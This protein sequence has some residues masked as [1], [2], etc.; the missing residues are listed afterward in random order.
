[1]QIDFSLCGD[2]GKYL[3]SKM[4]ADDAL[5][6]EAESPFTLLT[7]GNQ[8]IALYNPIPDTVPPNAKDVKHMVV[9]GGYA[10]WFID[11][12]A[13]RTLERM[14]PTATGTVRVVVAE[15]RDGE[16]TIDVSRN[17]MQAAMT[18]SRPLGGLAVTV[19]DVRAELASAGVVFGI[20]DEVIDAAVTSGRADSLVVAEGA[21]PR[22]GE[23]CRFETLYSEDNSN[24]PKVDSNGRAD[25]HELEHFVVV[26][27]GDPLMKRI[28]ATKGTPGSDVLGKPIQCKPGRDQSFAAKL[29][30]AEIASYNQNLLIAAI[31][32]LPQKVDRGVTVKPL[33]QVPTVDITTGNIHFEGSVKVTGDVVS[34]TT[35]SATEDIIVSG[36][37]EGASLI[38]GRDIQVGQG[39]IGRRDIREED[40]TVS[41]HATRVLCGGDLSAR[42]IEKAFV[43]TGRDIKVSTLIM[44]SEVKAGGNLTVG[45]KHSAKG[46]IVNGVF[47][48]GKLVEAKVL[49]SPGEVNTLIEVGIGTISHDVSE[50]IQ[51]KLLTLK[52]DK[53]KLFNLI[54]HLKT[55]GKPESA[56]MLVNARQRLRQIHQEIR[57]Q[58]RLHR[59]ARNSEQC[60]IDARVVVHA[61]AYKGVH[62]HLC[63]ISRSVEEEIGGGVFALNDNKIGFSP[64]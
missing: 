49:G 41:A 63:G 45:D 38:A 3:V 58:S 15:Q 26:K 12:E 1:M 2:I 10:A 27:K 18:I 28:P 55:D 47:K 8:V 36:T 32:G 39:I 17:V 35:V 50:S 37:V 25:M 16:V 19:D 13:I 31:G 22:N 11:E 62:V 57:T 42:F 23:D 20:K 6:N 4:T 54:R 21:P 64:Q 34:G 46:H 40:G 59:E 30:G 7:E 29:P 33:L 14:M 9:T 43:E 24:H 5:I 52:E 61:K 53:K 44:H 56:N 60:V 51:G 48:A